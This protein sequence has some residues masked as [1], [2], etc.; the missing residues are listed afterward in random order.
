M[1]PVCKLEY[2]TKGDQQPR[3]LVTCGHTF[4]RKCLDS[5]QAEGDKVTCPQC[6][7]VSKDPHVPNI[8]IMNYVEAQGSQPPPT[9]H[10]VPA[11]IKALCQDCKKD[12]ATLICF[13]CLVSGFKFCKNCCEREHN[14][15]FGPVKDHSPKDIEKV[16]ISTPVPTCEDHPG[17]PCLF[18]SFKVCK[19]YFLLALVISYFSVCQVN[20]FACELCGEV[21]NFAEDDYIPIERAVSKIREEVPSLVELLRNRVDIMSRTRSDLD[22]LLGKVD[23]E[24]VE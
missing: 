12:I 3:F 20:S 14:R 11:P 16:R 2:T 23:Q 15:S 10:H 1:C 17:K 19:F 24:K 7:I 5:Q 21:R 18:F 6:S 8:A 9:I 4:C 22:A 13:Q